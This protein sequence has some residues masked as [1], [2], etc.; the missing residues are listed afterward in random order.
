MSTVLDLVASSLLAVSTFPWFR[1]LGPA[2]TRQHLLLPRRL[3]PPPPL[4][5]VL[6]PSFKTNKSSREVWCRAQNVS[7]SGAGTEYVL[8]R[9]CQ[10]AVRSTV[11]P[12]DLPL[13]KRPS[14]QS[15]EPRVH[16]P[17]TGTG[18]A[19]VGF[20]RGQGI[21]AGSTS[22]TRSKTS[23]SQSEFSPTG[24]S[25]YSPTPHHGL[26]QSLHRRDTATEALSPPSKA[27]DSLGYT[28]LDLPT[29]TVVDLLC[30]GSC[31]PPSPRVCT[32]SDT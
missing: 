25:Y 10:H 2:S 9:K 15:A 17:R 31:S 8:H 13:V 32:Y 21:Q 14:I 26:E 3:C 22:L 30:S 18:T 1:R 20:D 6:S 4:C 11:Q 23:F 29:I 7:Y 12:A 16:T 28:L 24:A 19:A 27:F 5:R